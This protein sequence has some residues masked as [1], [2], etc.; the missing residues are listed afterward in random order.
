MAL[1]AEHVGS[2]FGLISGTVIDGLRFEVILV[3]AEPPVA[4]VV[5]IEMF[6]GVAELFD[7]D[8]VGHAIFNPAVDLVAKLGGKAGDF[9]IA[10]GPGLAGLKLAG[11]VMLNG[12]GVREEGFHGYWNLDL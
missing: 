2:G 5:I 3:T 4:E 11:Q 1:I 10:T 8:F 7:D 12:L 6:A 9:A